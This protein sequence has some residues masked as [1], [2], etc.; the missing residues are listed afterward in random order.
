[1]TRKILLLTIF[2]VLAYGFWVSPEFKTIAAGVAIFLLGMY[3][4]EEGFKAFSGGVLESFL[5]KTT[6]TTWKSL[7]FGI[8]STTLMQ[9][10]SLVSVITISF[11]SAGLIALTQGIGIIFGAN[12]GTTT[13]A[14]LVAGLGLKIDI[15]AYAM[16]M[17]VFGVI[18]IF[19]KGTKLQGAG[20]ALVGLGF[21]FLG[22]A[23]MK[24]G[25]EAFKST[26]D[27]TQ[28]AV[29]GYPGLFLF[30]GLNFRM[31]PVQEM[32]QNLPDP[33]QQESHSQQIGIAT[34][35]KL[36]G[37][38]KVHWIYFRNEQR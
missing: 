9:S 31:H 37:V 16:P 22:I 6:D 13:G 15:A 25:F 3:A 26:I 2:A 14:W 8:V 28:F 18:M 33:K 34:Q 30:A 10:S 4:L 7:T 1:M 19:Q 35:A 38:N 20:W 17:L 21:L 5:Q 32:R 24:E 27:L 12:L 11:L 36:M 23:Y 29:A